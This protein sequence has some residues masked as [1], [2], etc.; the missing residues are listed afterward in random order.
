VTPLAAALGAVMRERDWTPADL[1][2]A[3]DIKEPTIRGFTS[4]R[5]PRPHRH[6]REALDLALAG[7]GSGTTRRICDGEIDP[8]RYP[9]DDLVRL[10]QAVQ[11]VRA[12][13]VA[14]LAI[15]VDMLS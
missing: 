11:R 6:Q 8:P 5:V 14:P 12:D 15:I 2:R 3:T 13:A 4:G 1:A 9:T 7:G 10:H